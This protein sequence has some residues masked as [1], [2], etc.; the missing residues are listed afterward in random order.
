MRVN[1]KASTDHTHGRGGSSGS[2]VM[3]ST[4]LYSTRLN[5]VIVSYVRPVVG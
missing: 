2:M 1:L 4:R 3:L 5:D